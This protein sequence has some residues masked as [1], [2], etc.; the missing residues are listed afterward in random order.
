MESTSA[1]K[2]LDILLL[3]NTSQ[4]ELTVDE[5]SQQ[6]QIPISTVY[7][8]IRVLSDKGFLEKSGTK[9]YR[10]GLRFVEL[11]RVAGGS[12][13][14]LRLIALPSMKRIADQIIET[15]SLMRLFNKYAICIESIE[16]RHVVRVI[17]E[18]GRLQPLH[19]GASSKVLL[20]WL[21]ENEWDSYLQVPLQSI[22][23]NTI[24]NV[25][26]YKKQLRQTREQGYAT[27]DGEIDD[28]GR[29]IAVPLF[30]GKGKILAA[31]SVE[32]PS[33]RMTDDIMAD[34]LDLLLTEAETIRQQLA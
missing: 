13:R 31:L 7:R 33:F 30:D 18:Q 11:N 6:S 8:Y 15:V 25:D 3:F 2:V 1:H 5:I 17:I 4:P 21:D 16:G 29:A 9:S 32:G 10:L 23:E 27:S 28:G 34:Y 20:A 12:N 24:I 22:T 26:E 19:T 14:D